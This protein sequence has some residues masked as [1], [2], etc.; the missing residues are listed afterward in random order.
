M[1]SHTLLP[2]SFFSLHHLSWLSELSVTPPVKASLF[3][4]P[5][6]LWH[7]RFVLTSL[8]TK[9]KWEIS[10]LSS[11]WD[12]KLRSWPLVIIRKIPLALLARA[13]PL[14]LMSWQK[15]SLGDY[16]YILPAFVAS[17]GYYAFLPWCPGSLCRAEIAGASVRA[18]W[19]QDCFAQ[20]GSSRDRSR[21]ASL[22]APH[23]GFSFSPWLLLYGTE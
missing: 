19:T 5:H 1:K 7:S 13:R 17:D 16:N 6:A 8:R 15:S 23:L 9:N 12:V 20:V 21:A 2:C 14:A 3:L 11:K 18:G 10:S 4:S 22:P